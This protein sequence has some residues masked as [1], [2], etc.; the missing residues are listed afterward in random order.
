MS[1]RELRKGFLIVGQMHF[2]ITVH[3]LVGGGWTGFQSPLNPCL[4]HSLLHL[5][6]L[7]STSD[8]LDWF[9]TQ[10]CPPSSLQMAVASICCH[11]VHGGVLGRENPDLSPVPA[12]QANAQHG[13]A[14]GQLGVEGAVRKEKVQHRRLIC[15]M[16]SRF[17][18]IFFR[19]R[20]HLL[21]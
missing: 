12:I 8:P 11:P 7:L 15:F 1:F 9:F 21:F 10:D 13:P 6:A 5:S 20:L 14:W 16:L 4:E 19:K 2:P 17:H 3:G 18:V